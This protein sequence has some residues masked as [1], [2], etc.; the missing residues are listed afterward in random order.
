MKAEFWHDCWE[1]GRLGFHQSDFNRHMI[2]F[3]P[4]LGL[5]PG[6]HLLVP[7]CGKSLDMLWL[8]KQGYAVTGIELSQK[9]VEDF[10]TENRLDYEREDRDGSVVYRFDRLEI[11]CADLFETGLKV[12]DPI[13]A[14]YDRA[15][16][17][18]LPAD[19]RRA[20][21]RL[22]LD[23]LPLNTVILMQAME[24]DQHEMD[25]PPFSV[26]PAEIE[27]LY[28]IC[29]TI[30]PLLSEACLDERPNFRERGL[31]RL[32]DHVYAIRKTR[33]THHAGTH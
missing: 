9:A 21:A 28:G 27:D 4:G 1:Q 32:T 19:M 2:E 11:V 18:A 25:G 31:T 33:E 6:A 14:V 24:Y 3:M 12:C 7:L 23:Q 29:C 22:M 17:P 8:L 30:E 15:A 5:L 16:L 13:D 10:F 26:S 20:Y